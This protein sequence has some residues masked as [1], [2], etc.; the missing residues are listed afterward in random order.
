MLEG[1]IFLDTNILVYAH[2]VSAGRKHEIARELMVDL[3]N[4][5]TG[6]LSTQVLQ[7]FFVNVIC[8]IPKPLGA[9][10]VKGIISDLLNWEIVLN[11]AESILRAVDIHLQYQYSFWDALIIEAALKGCARWLFSEDL[12]HGQIIEGL[13][14]KNPF[15]L[16]EGSTQAF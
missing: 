4:S 11:D 10:L 1:R 13:E 14:I 5:H 12:S 9:K 15:T 3:W 6:V 16:L 7:E 2:D 8:K